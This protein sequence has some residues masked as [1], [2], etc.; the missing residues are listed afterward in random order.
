MR[1]KNRVSYAIIII[2]MMA[3]KYYYIGL[4]PGKFE[5]GGTFKL[6]RLVLA[7]GIADRL[8]VKYR[9]DGEDEGGPPAVDEDLGLPPPAFKGRHPSVLKL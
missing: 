4:T 3:E 6:E 7:L 9:G 2:A 1:P 8:R 5:L